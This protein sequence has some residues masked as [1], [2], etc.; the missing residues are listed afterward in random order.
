[1]C[2]GKR[3]SPVAVV[4]KRE[5]AR[6]CEYHLHI[7]E[8]SAARYLGMLVGWLQGH[9]EAQ[10]PSVHILWSSS[11]HAARLSLPTLP[12]TPVVSIFLVVILTCYQAFPTNPANLACDSEALPIINDFTDNCANRAILAGKSGVGSNQSA[13]LQGCTPMAWR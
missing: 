7:A 1:M 6:T 5:N 12:T 8:V 13:N 10:A 9:D 3:R 11:Q 4:Q 2:L